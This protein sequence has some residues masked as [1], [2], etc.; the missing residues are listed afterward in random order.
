MIFSRHVRGYSWRD[1]PGAIVREL[2]S[3]VQ[4]GLYGY[5]KV[6]VW[7]VDSYLA[8]TIPEMLSILRDTT[9]GYPYVLASWLPIVEEDDSIGMPLWSAILTYVI[10]GFEGYAY[11]S[12]GKLYTEDRFEPAGEINKLHPFLGKEWT[13]E[14]WEEM[15]AEEERI[16]SEF[17]DAMA[18]FVEIFPNLWD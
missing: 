1:K 10:E 15:K 9:H 6:D 11:L 7:N 18:V 12:D 4:R 17:D 14:Q 8:R 13:D 3:F 16:I 5:S 2:K